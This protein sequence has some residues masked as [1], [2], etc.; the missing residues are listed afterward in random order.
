MLRYKMLT[1]KIDD[2]RE[3]NNFLAK[4][5]VTSPNTPAEL[6]KPKIIMIDKSRIRTPD[7]ILRVS[8]ESPKVQSNTKSP[9]WFSL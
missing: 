4:S 3:P 1:E 7:M 2:P 5:V 9:H 8:P 6:K